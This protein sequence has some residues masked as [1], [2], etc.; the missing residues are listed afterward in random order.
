[1][2]R[3]S[4]LDN[5][6]EDVDIL[7]SLAE[8]SELLGE[9]KSSEKFLLAILAT[10]ELYANK[11]KASSQLSSMIR[12]LKSNKNT[13]KFFLLYRH[14]GSRSLQA[15]QK[16]TKLYL[17]SADYERALEVSAAAVC[18]IT[19]ELEH[20]VKMKHFLY[21]Y[22]GLADLILK[23]E[24]DIEIMDWANERKFW[25]SYIQ[26]ADILCTVNLLSQAEDLYE[27]LASSVPDYYI[28]Q[29]AL[30]AIQKI[31][32]NRAEAKTIKAK[33]DENKK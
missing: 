28:T 24:N 6:E 31:R 16:L 8:T 21:D 11:D 3:R 22:N 12:S 2:E 1:M 7:Y 26:F 33:K 17:D 25:Q 14:N 27:N 19:S 4:F 15:F 23:S 18:I 32:T 13:K 30:Y 10:D 29:N 9:T 20:Y 5:P